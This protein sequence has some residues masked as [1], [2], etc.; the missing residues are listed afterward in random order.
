MKT[1]KSCTGATE[2]LVNKYSHINGALFRRNA[3]K[4]INFS[5]YFE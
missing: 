1:S 5:R 3:Q 4:I 2:A